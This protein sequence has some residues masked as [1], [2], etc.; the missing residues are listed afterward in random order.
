EDALATFRQADRF[1]TPSVSRWTWLLGAGWAHL[2]MG[3]G[4]EAVPWMRRSI[5]IT[6]GSGRSHMMLAAAYQRAGRVDEAKAAMAEGL[7]LV[8]DTTAL[9]IAPPDKNSSPVYVQA[10]A[11]VVQLMVA[12]G[13]PER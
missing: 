5:A 9:N 4:E 1:D 12:A 11:R 3:H 8:P 6:P 10:T 13:L 7:K 2:L